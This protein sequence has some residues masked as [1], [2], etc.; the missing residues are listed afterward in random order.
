[1][2]LLSIITF[3]ELNNIEFIGFISFYNMMFY[4]IL[5]YNDYII[6]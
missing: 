4:N 6:M 1:L 3:I 2:L 5:L